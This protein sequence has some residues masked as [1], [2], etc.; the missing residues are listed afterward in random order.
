MNARFNV[1][2][3]ERKRLVTALGEV[4]G[5]VAVYNGAPTFSYTVGNFTVD[6]SGTVTAET[7]TN[8][9]YSA[10]VLQRLSEQ[11]FT[12]EHS[13]KVEVLVQEPTTIQNDKLII[14]M[15]LDGFTDATIANLCKLVESKASLIKKALGADSLPIQQTE[16]RLCFPWF[17]PQ[18]DVAKVR[19]Y[20]HFIAA[21]CEMAKTQQRVNATE[22]SV[23]NEKY[24]FRCFLL[25]LGF[26]GTECK[27]ER[28]IL[29]QNLSGNGAFK[30]GSAKQQNT[31][32]AV[33]GDE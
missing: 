1:T 6:K 12:V 3:T 21:L 30:N 11:G 5:T 26:I 28:K 15:P 17:A 13:S 10:L 23:D 24:S 22:K 27:A 9:E 25:R 33:S 16:G 31:S 20:T 32:E 7:S 14:E 8:E 19:V 18:G 29:L 4:V 2:G